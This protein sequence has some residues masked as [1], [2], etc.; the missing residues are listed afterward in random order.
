[1]PEGKGHSKKLR[2]AVGDAE[3]RGSDAEGKE[4]PRARAGDLPKQPGKEPPAS[5]EHKRDE[6]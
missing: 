2:R 5:D 3:R 1:M 4:F 6:N